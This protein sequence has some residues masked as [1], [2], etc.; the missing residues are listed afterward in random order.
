MTNE[1]KSFFQHLGSFNKENDLSDIIYFGC[2]SSHLFKQLFLKHVFPD[3]DINNITNIDDIE[4]EVWSEDKSCRV[5][6]KFIVND[7]IYLVENKI[8]DLD[9]HYEFYP[10]K[11]TKCKIGYIANYDVQD[12]RYFYKTSWKKFIY[13]LDGYLLKN[14]GNDFI[15]YMN[16]YIKEVC[17]F[18]EERKF[19]HMQ[20]SD[21]HYVIQIIEKIIMENGKRLQI[22]NK[23]KGCSEERIGKYFWLDNNGVRYHFWFGLYL[24]D[25]VNNFWFEVCDDCDNK[26]NGNEIAHKFEG[27]DN[28]STWF[29]I[30]GKYLDILK[31]D[32]QSYS[33]KYKVLSDFFE[34]VINSKIA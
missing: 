29:N 13:Y 3:I 32:E 16:I 7:E 34:Y 21:L 19:N 1:M 12:I 23:A 31:D 4:R 5:D 18:M 20:T 26:Y 25:D 30:T 14:K 27:N 17:D 9:D 24:N 10:E 11:F 22:N 33:N 15:H 8:Y 6:F 28:N 2:I